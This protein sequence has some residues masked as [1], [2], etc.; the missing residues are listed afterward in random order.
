MEK[1]KATYLIVDK[2]VVKVQWK[3]YPKAG[4]KP[5]MPFYK[6]DDMDDYT[7]SLER[8]KAYGDISAWESN[9]Q[10]EI[11]QFIAEAIEVQNPDFISQKVAG[12]QDGISMLRLMSETNGKPLLK[13]GIYPAPE[14]LVFEVRAKP[15]QGMC[16]VHS[17][18]HMEKYAICSFASEPEKEPKEYIICSANWYD[19]GKEYTFSPKNV[20][21]GFVICGRRHHNCI[22]TFTQIVGFP[23]TEEGHKIHNTEK[24][25]FLT[26]TNRWVDRKEGY[27]IAFAADQ[28][29]GPNKG[30]SENSIGL[31]SEDLY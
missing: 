16:I 29:K 22:S 21:S 28:I 2:G 14:G 10:Q 20:D 8:D 9:Y 15:Q 23:Y 30:H 17:P 13:D 19:D 27:K 12:L 25:G 4:E 6:P 3:T 26:N 1:L 11:D 24:Q 18:K 31:T 7:Y 5:F